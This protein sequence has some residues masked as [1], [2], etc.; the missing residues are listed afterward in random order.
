MENWNLVFLLNKDRHIKGQNQHIKGQNQ[1]SP[2]IT[3]PVSLDIM[4]YLKTEIRALTVLYDY[5]FS[6]GKSK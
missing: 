1:L 3:H 6:F 2:L 5:H 4:L